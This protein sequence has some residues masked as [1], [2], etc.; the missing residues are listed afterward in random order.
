MNTPRTPSAV[1]L[2]LSVATLLAAGCQK[3]HSAL[4]PVTPEASGIAR[5]WWVFF[6]VCVAVYIIVM[7]WVVTA[8]A[9]KRTTPS[10]PPSAAV[11]VA[12]EG[13]LHQVIGWSAAATAVIVVALLIA[14]LALQ[15]S[16]PPRK[17]DPLVIRMTGR[18]WWWALE[19]QNPDPSKVFE[20][21]NEIHVPTGRSIRILL[22]S[23]DVIHSFWVPQL[24]GKK[25][26]V[27]GHSNSISFRVDRA[28]RYDGQCAEFCG[29]QHAHMGIRVVAQEPAD[30]EAW[31]SRQQAEPAP[32]TQASA[33]HGKEVFESTTC[34][35]CHT[36]NGTLAHSRVGPVLTHFASRETLAAGT[37]LNQRDQRRTWITNPQGLKPGAQMP[38][39]TLAP[40]DLEALLDYLETLQ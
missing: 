24:N 40:A 9:R 3:A 25:D 11:D 28:G 22:E 34:A 37:A 26:L 10:A 21:A 39:A 27:P 17:D 13:K 18:Q 35:S 20:T 36:V 33:L 30:Y 12:Q 23:A 16:Q 15:R 4:A 32:P 31:A 29:Y 19:Y 6:G 2:L 5:L 8:R 14:D 7:L 38:A 1:S